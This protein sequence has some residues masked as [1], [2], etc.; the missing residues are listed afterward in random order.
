[1]SVNQLEWEQ[2]KQIVDSGLPLKKRPVIIVQVE[3]E[4]HIKNFNAIIV[5][6]DEN[7]KYFHK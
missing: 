4:P 2:I 3:D 5:R 7:K 1:M 6:A